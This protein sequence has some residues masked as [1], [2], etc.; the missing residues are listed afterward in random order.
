MLPAYIFKSV[1]LGTKQ[2]A[3]GP[4]GSLGQPGG[5]EAWLWGNDT[6]P[7][8]AQVSPGHS[9][10]QNCECIDYFILFYYLFSYFCRVNVAAAVN[11]LNTTSKY[12]AGYA[13]F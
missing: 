4:G 10:R 2:S 13:P 5:E 7:G 6:D 11:V 12:I 3:G 9:M 1:I 8:G